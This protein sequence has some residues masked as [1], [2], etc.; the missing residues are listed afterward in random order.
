MKLIF[1]TNLRAYFLFV[2]MTAAGPA[3]CNMTKHKEG[4][5]GLPWQWQQLERCPAQ[6]PGAPRW[7]PLGCGC[8]RALGGRCWRG[9][10]AAPTV[11]F[12]RITCF[13]C[14]PK[15]IFD[16]RSRGLSVSM[17]LSLIIQ[18][19]CFLGHLRIMLIYEHVKEMYSLMYV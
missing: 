14:L 16:Q 17:F 8:R 3:L 5:E 18:C 4:R 19:L 12:V 11:L 10:R 9:H 1:L 13:V 6:G 15:N 2:K 7:A